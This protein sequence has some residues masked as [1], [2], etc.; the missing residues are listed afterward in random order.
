[1]QCCTYGLVTLYRYDL[2]VLTGWYDLAMDILFSH[3]INVNVM[4][5]LLSTLW[6]SM[7]T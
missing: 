1:M 7:A 5:Q 4:G 3:A 6:S 2:V